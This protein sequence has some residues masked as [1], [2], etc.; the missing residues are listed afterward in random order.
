VLPPEALVPTADA[1][2]CHGLRAEVT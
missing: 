1:A 2:Q